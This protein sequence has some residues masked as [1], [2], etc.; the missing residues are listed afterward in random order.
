MARYFGAPLERDVAAGAEKPWHLQ[1]ARDMFLVIPAI[2]L[3]LEFGVDV[4]PHRSITARKSRQ[5]PNLKAALHERA[6]FLRGLAL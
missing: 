5:Y 6:S 4:G 1:H 2:E 3:G